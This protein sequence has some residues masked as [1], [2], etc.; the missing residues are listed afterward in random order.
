M[1]ISLAVLGN[2][3]ESNKT[4]NLAAVRWWKT[5]TPMV[6]LMKYS[7]QARASCRIC[8]LFTEWLL[9]PSKASHLS[10]SCIHSLR[11]NNSLIKRS[12]ELDRKLTSTTRKLEQV[13]SLKAINH[14][15]RGTG[16]K[17]RLNHS[18]GTLSSNPSL[19]VSRNSL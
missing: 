12:Q 8:K 19:R 1:K 9:D 7:I 17:T 18:L 11:I 14:N 6:K 16:R 2:Y 3:S 4:L 15:S 5:N 10:R 13:N